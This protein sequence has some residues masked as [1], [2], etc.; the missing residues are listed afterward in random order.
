LSTLFFKVFL[1]LL[2]FNQFLRY[3]LKNMNLKQQAYNQIRQKIIQCEYPPHMLLN[4]EKL[5]EELGVSRTPIRDALGRLEQES[6]VQILPKKGIIVR[7]IAPE[8]IEHLFEMRMLLEPYAARNY[9]HTIPHQ[10]YVGLADCF[11][12]GTENL[13]FETVYRWDDDF[14]HLFI[15]ASKNSFLIHA[16]ELSFAQNIRLRILCGNYGKERVKKSQTEHQVILAHCLETD[17]EAAALAL[18]FHLE[19]AKRTSFAIANRLPYL[20]HTQSGLRPERQ[21][22]NNGYRTGAGIFTPLEP[23]AGYTRA[24]GF[25]R[26]CGRSGRC[27]GGDSRQDCQ[28]HFLKNRQWGHAGGHRRGHEAGQPQ[29]QRPVQL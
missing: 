18:Q 12:S 19:E 23:A 29:I 13:S 10:V 11:A 5:R 2:V 7:G 27:F 15:N 6:L 8:E 25:H 21:G 16:Y 20:F 26:H 17:W 28:K 4:E 3:S 9:G 24:C 22:G 1:L 14:H